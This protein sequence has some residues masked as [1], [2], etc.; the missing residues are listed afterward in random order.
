MKKGTWLTASAY[1]IWGFLPIFWKQIHHLAPQEILGHRIIWSFS[2][3][4]LLLHSRRQWPLLIKKCKEKKVLFTYLVTGIILSGNWLTFIWAVNNNYLIEASLGYFLNPLIT[5]L[6][7]VIFLKET[8]RPW[9]WTAMVFVFI[10]ILIPT[11][12]YGRMPWVA[13]ILAFSFAFYSLIKKTGP[14]ESI[15]SLTLETGWIFL[16]GLLGII[17]LTANGQ[18]QVYAGSTRDLIF[19][20]FTGLATTLPL[21]LFTAGARRIPLSQVG[22]LQY[23]APTIQLLLG[24]IVYKEQFS[25]AQF[26]GFML[27]WLAI[28]LYIAEGIIFQKRQKCPAL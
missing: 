24:I 28:L 1:L 11:I 18:G 25:T 4:V 26:G 23:L 21:L 5:V 8:L 19:L 6:L 15:P 16:P 22:I 12:Q 2:F 3:L 27:V 13:L 10:G 14:L 17:V 20:A 7:G 9:Q